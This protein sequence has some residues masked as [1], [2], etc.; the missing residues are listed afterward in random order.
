MSGTIVYVHGASDRGGGVADHVRRIRESLA[1]RGSDMAV[2][3][4]DSG[5]AAG[6][7]L[8]RVLVATPS[9]S[10]R[11]GRPRA[12][13]RE[14]G[15]GRLL[16]GAAGGIIALQYLNVRAPARV[17][18]WATDVLLGRRDALM[19][20]I[21]GVADVLVYQR[22][23]TAI[24]EHVR[25]ALDAVTDVERPLVALGKTASAEIVLFD[26]LRLTRPRA[27]FSLLFVIPWAHRR[28]NRGDLSENWERMH[29]R[30]SRPGS[31]STTGGVLAFIARPVLAGTTRHRG[32]VW[33]GSRPRISGGARA[34]VLPPPPESVFDRHLRAII[35]KWPPGSG[36]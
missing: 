19:Q 8:D 12:A 16:Q 18:V 2:V 29:A 21:L 5:D 28:A 32:P 3:A 33:G 4:A 24:R 15:F 27:T 31:T 1:A 25:A 13:T 20:E 7:T 14:R 30:P 35:R 9:D 10:P 22:A 17:R 6:P 36:S 23:G 34:G 11:T 26:V